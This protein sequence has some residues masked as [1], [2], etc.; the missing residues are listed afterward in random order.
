MMKMIMDLQMN[1]INKMSKKELLEAYDETRSLL[2]GCYDLIF[3]WKAE[4]PAQKEWKERWLR[5]AK[6]HGASLDW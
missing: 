3:I 1:D 2:D 6:K 4:S 5:L